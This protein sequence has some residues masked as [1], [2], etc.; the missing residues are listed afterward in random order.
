MG[1]SPW[2][3][4][5]HRTLWAAPTAL[6][7]VW[8]AHQGAQVRAVIGQPRVLAWLAVSAALLS[9][10]WSTFIWAVNSGRVLESSLGYYINPLLN[11]AAGAFL[12]RER[13][14]RPALLAIGLATAG[15]V[16]QALALGHVPWISLVLAF[17]FCAYG[18]VR[19]RVAADAQT[20]LF[21]E[22]LMLAAPSLAYMA[23]LQ[24]NGASTA[25]GSPAALLWL[26]AC[27][28]LTALPLVLFAWAARRI[29]FSVM[30]FLQFIAPT[31]TFFLGLAQGEA[32]TPLRALSFVFIWCGAA[33][34]VFGALRAARAPV[35]SAA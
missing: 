17:S 25:Q 27:G 11:I 12:F 1:V 18:V 15:V 9:V 28:P 24:A 8:M 26:I 16:L 30:G 19:K 3:I 10:N 21:I 5:A 14:S 2:E 34:F 13:L 7:F 20:G 33:V 23:W 6:L 31:M 35:Q 29:P 32:F 22:C 4:L